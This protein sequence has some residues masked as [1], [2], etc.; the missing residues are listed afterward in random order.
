[1]PYHV[2]AHINDE[3]VLGAL[4]PSAVVSDADGDRLLAEHP[5]SLTR[6]AHDEDMCAV[7]ETTCDHDSHAWNAAPTRNAPTP[8]TKYTAPLAAETTGA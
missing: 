7:A 2:I 6:I 4:S 5:G 1:M 8:I 3:G